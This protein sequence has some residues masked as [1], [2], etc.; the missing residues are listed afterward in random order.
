[1]QKN[2]LPQNKLQLSKLFQKSKL[3]KKLC[4]SLK[5]LWNQSRKHLKPNQSKKKRHKRL[6]TSLSRLLKKS[7]LKKRLLRS[8]RLLNK[9]QNRL[10]LPFF[11][12]TLKVTKCLQLMVVFR[13]RYL[14]K[15]LKEANRRKE[16]SLRLTTSANYL[17]E[18]S[19]TH[20]RSEGSQSK[21]RLELVKWLKDGTLL[22]R[23]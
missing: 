9:H 11:T 19:L 12:S 21:S 6:N 20:Q 4:K 14:T 16:M 3:R 10:P 5:K 1:M 7:L 22:S 17:M 18:Q 23:T 2:K 15:V 8:S 13:R